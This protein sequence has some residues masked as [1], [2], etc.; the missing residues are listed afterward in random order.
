MERVR[1]IPLPQVCST[2]VPCPS[3]LNTPT[4]LTLNFTQQNS[5]V[6]VHHGSYAELGL[7]GDWRSD[8]KPEA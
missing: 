6:Y 3:I 4:S 5:R 7:M 8:Y 2:D 1:L